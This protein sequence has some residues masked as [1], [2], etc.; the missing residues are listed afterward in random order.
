MNGAGELL[1]RLKKRMAVLPRTRK[2]LNRLMRARYSANGLACIAMSACGVLAVIMLLLPNYL[3]MGNDSLANAKMNSY[4][5]GYID[6]AIITGNI[7]S[8]VLSGS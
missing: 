2:R 3:G 4:Q 1:T 7:A 6:D 5:L 8:N